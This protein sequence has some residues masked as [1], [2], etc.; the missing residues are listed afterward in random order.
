MDEADIIEWQKG[1]IA[2]LELQLRA[3]KTHN[4][5]L[6]VAVAHLKEAV[7]LGRSACRTAWANSELESGDEVLYNGI[8]EDTLKLLDKADALLL[9]LADLA[10]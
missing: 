8:N 10:K 6:M 3:E 2:K 7:G 5:R 9:P 4:N 1:V